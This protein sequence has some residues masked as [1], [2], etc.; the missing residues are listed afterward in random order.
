MKFLVLF[1]SLL[2]FSCTPAK[3][4]EAKQ[5]PKIDAK[6]K[7]LGRATFP[8]DKG[9]A[10]FAKGVKTRLRILPRKVERE[11]TTGYVDYMVSGDPRQGQKLIK[12]LKDNVIKDQ[13]KFDSEWMSI[14]GGGEKLKA[15]KINLGV[16]SSTRLMKLLSFG[17]PT[18][19]EFLLIYSAAVELNEED[20]KR[21]QSYRSIV[22]SSY[23]EILKATILKNE[24]FLLDYPQAI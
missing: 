18:S 10:E 3:K 23:G 22:K 20:A 17:D 21:I 11:F 8:K 9:F 2:L 7:K 6:S 14:F 4:E 19:I 12:L 15:K 1:A 13:K 5:Q 16:M 24:A